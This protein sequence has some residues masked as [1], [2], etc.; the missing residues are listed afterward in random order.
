MKIREM[1]RLAIDIYKT[2]DSSLISQSAE[3][4]H[5]KVG[6]YVTPSLTFKLTPKV[7]CRAK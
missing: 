5:Q 2:A 7:Y 6:D 4:S 1:D 3:K